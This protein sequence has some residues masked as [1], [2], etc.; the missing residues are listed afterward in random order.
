MTILKGTKHWSLVIVL[1]VSTMLAGCQSSEQQNSSE[2]KG[3]SQSPALGTKSES[4]KQEPVTITWTMRKS[5]ETM[6]NQEA[7]EEAVNK[8][9]AEKLNVKL[10]LNLIDAGSWDDKI[11]LMSAAGEPFDLVLSPSVN[12]FFPNAARGAYIPI[13]DLIEKYGADI[14]NKVDPRAWKAVTV[15]GNILA[16]PSQTPYS[17]PE[18]FAFKKELVEKYN[19]DAKSVKTIQ[20]LE[21][22]LETIKKNEPSL[23]PMIATGK[24]AMTGTYTLANPTLMSMLVYH[25]ESGKV[26][27]D[28]EI[29]ENEANLRTIHDYYKKG[30]IAKDAAVKTDFLAEAKSG[31]YAVLR[32]SGGYTEDGSKSSSLFGFP[33][34]EALYGYPLIGTNRMVAPA[35]AIS[36]TSQNP[37]LAMQLLN[38]VWAD[39]KISNTLAYGLEGQNY[40][41][42]A[43]QGTDTPT[44]QAKSGAEQTWAIWHNW[45]GPLWD[46]WDSNWNS[47]KA[48]EAMQENNK[49][50]ITSSILGFNVDTEPVKAEIA[51]LSAVFAELM[52]IFYTGS[53]PN[54]DNYVT[55]AKQKLKSAGL[56]KVVAEFQRQI[57]EWKAN[58]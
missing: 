1:L 18:S 43:G 17:N 20:D 53:M 15:K 12:S 36:A 51:Q 49:N 5:I 55:E 28:F 8:M 7:I 19:F 31:K 50:A 27:L 4:V 40:T 52:P 58:N 34:L 57:D 10:K 29:P 13:G 3:A 16:V 41:V 54:Y 25:E 14:K 42:T 33:T 2:T 38:L 46:Q 56:D 44:I 39:P 45:V 23:I 47:T 9:I 30:Y 11:K 24:V 6:K 35:T 22:F 48:L 26:S 32:D 21:P 37:E